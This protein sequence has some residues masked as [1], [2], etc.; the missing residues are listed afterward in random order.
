M[1]HPTLI[2]TSILW[3]TVAIAQWSTDPSI[4]TR[5]TN[6][7]LLPQIISDSNGGAYIV[8]Q[9]SPALLRQLWIQRLDRYGYVRFP[10]NGIRVGSEARNQTPYYFLVSDSMGGVII[11]F[12]DFQLIGNTTLGAVYAQ[13]IDSS[14]TK[15]WGNA[16]VEIS[17]PT[18]GKLPVSACSDGESG[19]FVFWG[20]DADSNNVPELWGQQVNASGKLVWPVKG[21]IVTDQLTSLN[22]A[23][24]NPAVPDGNRGAIVLYSDSAGTRLQRI[25]QQGNFLWKDGTYIFPV[26]RQMIED[27]Q[28]GAIIAGVRF[29][30]D[31]TS[32]HFNVEAQRVNFDGQ[33]LWGNDGVILSE[34]FDDEPRSL[35]LI[36][37]AKGNSIF[38]WH[39]KNTGDVDVYTQ[40][41]NCF[42][43]PQW[44][45]NGIAVSNFKSAKALFFSS[46]VSDLSLG[47]IVI[48]SDNRIGDGS[49]FAPDGLFGQRVDG[50][51]SR[52]W[53]E[54]DV[55]ISTRKVKHS[56]Y[57]IITD[58][59]GGAIAC[60]YEVGNESGF[61]IFAQQVS[62]NGNLGE[63]LSTSVSEPERDAVPKEYFLYQ[64]YPNPFHSSMVIQYELLKGTIVQLRI[65]DL[66]GK[67]VMTL[68]PKQCQSGFHE[69]I[70]DGRDQFGHPVSSGVYFYQL[71]TGT[72][73]QW[74][75]FILLR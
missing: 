53:G 51:G 13:R 72:A 44:M 7:G 4:N 63:I 69:V 47:A 54:V 22:V 57:R 23:I 62:K 20:E 21:I 73:T 34:S 46:I 67:E 29:M 1:Q 8:Y 6:G 36:V 55:A 19:V 66:N 74:R 28:G 71:S 70:W 18:H 48:W 27:G 31:S 75:K 33:V 40:K 2:L 39:E 38:V 15:L 59:V 24:P 5:V 61:G 50:N 56:S 30:L 11:V 42:G 37:D 17:P 16:G 9:D 60:W 3:T 49:L 64:S 45:K 35:D 68:V 43:D 58:G 25:N 52:L 14:G 41:L 26:G 12:Q 32:Y 65:L 10:D